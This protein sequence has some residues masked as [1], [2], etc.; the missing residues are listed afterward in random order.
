[1]FCGFLV[2]ALLVGFL[3]L[4]SFF[5]LFIWCMLV[6]LFFDLSCFF[7]FFSVKS[8]VLFVFCHFFVFDLLLLYC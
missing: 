6:V 4:G 3:F 7:L 5:S 8:C 1:M 2:F